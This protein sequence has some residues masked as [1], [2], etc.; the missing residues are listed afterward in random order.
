[1]FSSP[2]R[3]FQCLIYMHRY[4]EGTVGTILTGY[5]RQ[6]EDKLRARLQ[7]T[8]APGAS[9]AELREANK[10]RASIAELEAW[11]RDVVYPLAHERVSIDLDDGVKVNYNKLPR[12]L[13]KVPGLS[14]WR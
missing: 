7:A 13:A 10:I 8:D 2:K 9:A 11:E 6:M 4:D 12:A 3:T 1:M 14:D 5:L